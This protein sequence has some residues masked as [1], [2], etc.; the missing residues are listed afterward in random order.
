MKICCSNSDLS[1]GQ[2]P[3]NNMQVDIALVDEREQ[4]SLHCRSKFVR[5]PISVPARYFLR[6]LYVLRLPAWH[7][8]III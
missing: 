8:V 7:Q 1:S 4:V 2:D 5:K 6:N 3:L